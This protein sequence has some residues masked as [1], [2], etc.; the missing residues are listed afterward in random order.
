MEYKFE[1][2]KPDEEIGIPEE[3]S[4]TLKTIKFQDLVEEYDQLQEQEEKA[5]VRKE[6]LKKEIVARME[7][8]NVTE[9]KT[10]KHRAVL[11]LQEQNE[12]DLEK[13]SELDPSVIE[14]ISLPNLTIM[15]KVL[16]KDMFN[17][18]TKVKNVIK[19]LKIEKR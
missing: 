18:V 16:S 7:K 11:I 1:N 19:K 9:A 5:K 6:A 13:L 17:K 3:V 2:G 14:K 15:R 10:N 4:K 8:R 12:V